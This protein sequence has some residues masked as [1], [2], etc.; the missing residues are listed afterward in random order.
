[1]AMKTWRQPGACSACAGRGNTALFSRYA[2][3]AAL[4]RLGRPGQL[5]GEL[6]ILTPTS[7]KPSSSAGWKFSHWD[8]P[9]SLGFDLEYF[10]HTLYLR[11]VYLGLAGGEEWGQ[12]EGPQLADLH[13]GFRSARMSV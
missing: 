12:K 8:V 9:K 5:S 10:L 11:V 1:M 13:S 4:G 3:L 7:L 2:V 6:T